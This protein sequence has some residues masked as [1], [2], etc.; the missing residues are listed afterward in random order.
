MKKLIPIEANKD[1]GFHYTV[2]D[3]Q[4]AAHQKLSIAEIFQWLESTNRFVSLLQT[5]EE[6][7][8]SRDAK[9]FIG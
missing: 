1:K 4:I 6:K 3:E 5:E 9:N 7:K 8:R 2:T